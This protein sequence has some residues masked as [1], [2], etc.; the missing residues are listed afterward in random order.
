MQTEA[1]EPY[2][3]DFKQ[4]ADLLDLMSS[5]VRIEVLQRV[6]IREW[7]VTALETDLAMGQSALSQHLAKLR[8]AKLVSTRRAAQQIYYKSDSPAVHAILKTLEALGPMPMGRL[9][10]AQEAARQHR[11]GQRSTLPNVA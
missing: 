2:T 3:F 8:D 9:T 7:D 10:E 1:F 6:S 4:A 5:P 11:I